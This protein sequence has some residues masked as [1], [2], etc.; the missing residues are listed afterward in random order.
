MTQSKQ[1]RLGDELAVLVSLPIK[2]AVQINHLKVGLMCD[3]TTKTKSVGQTTYSTDGCYENWA[4]LTKDEQ[5]PGGQRVKGAHAFVIP[6]D[7]SPSNAKQY[8]MHDWHVEV[9]LDIAG[10]PDYRG[11]FPIGVEG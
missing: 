5:V 6:A 1:F 8:P 3:R 2:T 11:R 4:T 7:Q 10:S 9:R